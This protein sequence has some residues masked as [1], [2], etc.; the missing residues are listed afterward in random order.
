MRHID[1]LNTTAGSEKMPEN[2]DQEIQV[3]FCGEWHTVSP[4]HT[5]TI[6]R[7]ADLVVDDNPYLH[8]VFISLRWSELWWIDNVGT[9]LSA[10][11]SDQGG[12]MQSW[13]APGA[14]MPLIFPVTEVRFTAGP[15]NYEFGLHL[16][17]AP[18]RPSGSVMTSSG[19]TTL[20]PTRLTVNQK[21][22]VLAL[23]EAALLAPRASGTQIPSSADAAARLGWTITKFNRQLDSVCQK[24][25]KA[26]VQGLHGRSGDLASGR[27]S[28][29][30]E[31]VLATRLVTS[32][33]LPL[34]DSDPRH[35]EQDCP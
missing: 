20:R 23:A 7:T 35:D 32:E 3:E 14:S 29:L 22:L 30:V 26:G 15:T 24:L 10:T 6:G 12:T 18:M 1:L 8:R 34:L 31:Y 25:E 13:L 16:A 4:G 19:L 17:D 11:L 21:Q 33:D 27:R 2:D 9:A 28:R 5:F